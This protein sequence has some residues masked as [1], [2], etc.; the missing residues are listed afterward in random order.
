[1]LF[2]SDGHVAQD[3]VGR[4]AHDRRDHADDHAQCHR[5]N[6]HDDGVHQAPQNGLRCEELP[7]VG[8]F[9]L[10]IGKGAQQRGQGDHDQRGKKHP[11]VITTRHV[12]VLRDIELVLGQ[13]ALSFQALRRGLVHGV[14]PLLYSIQLCE[15]NQ[16]WELACLR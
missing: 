16:M 10:A 4:H 1:M 2:R 15:P 12:L 3:W 6:R 9:D 8:P 13:L 14:T 5:Q 11:P 7:D